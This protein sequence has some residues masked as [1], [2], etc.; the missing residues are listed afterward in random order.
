MR[1]DAWTYLSIR[2]MGAPFTVILLVLQVPS[3]S[4]ALGP[5]GRCSAQHAASSSTSSQQYMT[6]ALL[7]FLP[8]KLLHHCL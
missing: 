3:I 4:Y 7:V 1:S 2:G 5:L 8:P 6:G